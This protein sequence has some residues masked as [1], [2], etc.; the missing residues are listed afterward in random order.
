MKTAY[1]GWEAANMN[2]NTVTWAVPIIA[3]MT[4]RGYE[5]N[6]AMMATSSPGVFTAGKLAEILVQAALGDTSG[7]TDFG[8]PVI[9][10]GVGGNAVQNGI[11]TTAIL[12]SW[13]SSPPTA[14]AV[15]DI[16]SQTGVLK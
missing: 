5:I 14:N 6:L 16:L 12:K 10:P 8:P 11:F 13:V 7:N 2:G 9:N 15:N 4:I 3:P 1:F